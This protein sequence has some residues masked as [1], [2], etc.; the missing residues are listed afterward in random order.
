ME[1]PWT[2]PFCDVFQCFF[3]IIADILVKDFDLV[4]FQF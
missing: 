1:A 2:N 4:L 3:L